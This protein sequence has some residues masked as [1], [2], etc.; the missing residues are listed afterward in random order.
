MIVMRMVFLLKLSSF[1]LIWQL[2][3]QMLARVCN[4]A[5]FNFLV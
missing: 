2:G 3:Y 4:G 1:D 5:Y